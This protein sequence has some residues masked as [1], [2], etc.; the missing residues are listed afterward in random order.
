[1]DIINILQK[2]YPNM[3]SNIIK[4]FNINLYAIPIFIITLICMSFNNGKISFL[5]YSLIIFNLIICTCLS[6]FYHYFSHMEISYPLTYG[7][8]Y[9]HKDSKNIL[10]IILENL[11]EI[12]FLLFPI[13]LK[14]LLQLE[15]DVN[16]WYL[17][18][19]YVFLFYFVWSST[20]QINYSIFH[21]NTIHEKQ[22]K[23][24]FTNLGPEI[25]DLF[26]CTKSDDEFEDMGHFIPNIIIGLI[27]IYFLKQYWFKLNDNLQINYKYKFIYGF[28]ILTILSLVI[29]IY[30]CNKDLQ[31]YF[32]NDLNFFI[33]IIE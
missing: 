23:K 33:K 21:V 22:H 13:Y 29:N 12:S 14:L 4:S 18:N 16:L 2:W 20:H 11:W 31:E 26:F 30:L 5:K 7:H 8:F 3:C 28:S 6:Y 24:V 9:H 19:W 10:S 17:D 1:M 25:A 15:Y 32:K 27:I